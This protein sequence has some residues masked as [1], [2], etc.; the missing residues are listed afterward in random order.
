MATAA[1]AAAPTTQDDFYTFDETRLEQLRQ[2]KPWMADPK[3]IKKVMVSP[4][5]AMKMLMHAISGVERGIKTG[6]VPVEIMGLMIGRP[7]PEDPTRLVV[8]DVFPL[9]IEGAETRVLAD[10]AELGENLELTRKE[11]FM[12]WYHSH[13]FEVDIHSH[14]FMSAMDVSTQLGW[15][16]LEDRN[17]NPW[18]AVVVDPLRSIAKGRPEFGAFRVYPP[19]YN[20]PADETPDFK[21]VTNDSARV[22]RWGSCWNRYYILEMEYYMSSTAAAVLGTLSRSFLW[23][24]NLTHAPGGEQEAREKA[25]EQIGKMREKIKGMVDHGVPQLSLQR[26]QPSATPSSLSGPRGR[27]GPSRGGT[28]N[29]DAE[30]AAIS[31]DVAVD[32]LLHQV[33]QLAKAEVFNPST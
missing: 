23:M 12:G 16:R 13:P 5:A 21:I 29:G 25:R 20:A 19:E 22:E 10:D 9:P 33:T 27:G 2:E 6:G 31:S 11:R 7:D 26:L 28:R 4:G 30:T 18:L 8:T 1:G 24:S 15:Q 17:G 3:F 32:A 14:C